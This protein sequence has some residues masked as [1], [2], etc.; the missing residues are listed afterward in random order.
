MM[1]NI[2]FIRSDRLGEFLLSLYALKLVRINQPQARVHLIA[3]KENLELIRGID[4]VDNYVE[5]NERIFSGFSGAFRLAA[6]IRKTACDCVIV[7]NPKKEFHLAAW[8]SGSP[9]R[10]GYRR[11]WGFCLNKKI[12]DLKFQGVKH[13]IEYNLDLIKPICE[14]FFIPEVNLSVDSQGSLEFLKPTFN[15]DKKYVVIHPF[16]SHG[17]KKIVNDFWLKLINALTACGITDIALVGGANEVQESREFEGITKV[18]NFVGKL[19]LRNLAAFLKYNCFAFIGLDSGP[20]HLASILEIPT[21]GLFRA[22]SSRRWGPYQKGSLVIEGADIN[23]F[24]AKIEN[25]VSFVKKN[26]K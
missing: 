6:M 5:Y 2:V 25:I 19:S 13:E 22:S 10:A 21:V 4:C 12:E 17:Q 3:Q 9:I 11:K 18:K 16:T 26:K 15:L 7:L 1:R 14:K 24:I 8:L 23:T 20:M